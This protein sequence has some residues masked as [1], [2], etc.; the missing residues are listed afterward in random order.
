M[1]KRRILICYAMIIPNFVF[2]QT[3]LWQSVGNANLKHIQAQAPSDEPY[4]FIHSFYG[5]E[6]E[7]MDG[8]VKAKQIFNQLIAQQK[9]S[10]QTLKKAI[11][12]NLKTGQEFTAMPFK[13]GAK[14]Q[15]LT[16]LDK[17]FQNKFCHTTILT[18]FK[19]LL[20]G[21][22]IDIQNENEYRRELIIKKVVRK[23]E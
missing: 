11:S 21:F 17:A 10:E 13:I 7:Y 2:A 3:S 20:D 16:I 4:Y 14:T 12:Y 22:Q 1:I 23:D 9:M 18:P 5:L 15:Y 6:A 19:V 8:C